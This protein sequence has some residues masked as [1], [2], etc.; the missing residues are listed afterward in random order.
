M[1]NGSVRGLSVIETGAVLQNINVHH[2]YD[3]VNEYVARLDEFVYKH[4]AVCHQA[5]AATQRVMSQT[6]ASSHTGR[7]YPRDSLS[8]PMGC[9][10]VSY[11][12]ASKP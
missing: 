5:R 11:M 1:L 8:G 2:R 7:V 4:F 3:F 10:L 9:R 6:R 12:C